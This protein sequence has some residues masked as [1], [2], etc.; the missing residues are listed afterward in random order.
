M[1][2]RARLLLAAVLM[3]WIPLGLLGLAI[4]S[5]GAGRLRAAQSERME[6]RATEVAAA[7]ERTMDRMARALDGFEAQLTD[8]NRVR[9]AFRSLPRTDPVLQ[10]ATERF[11]AASGMD[12]AFI[13][14]ADGTVAAASH[15][16][17]DVG[18]TSALLRSVASAGD[19]DGRSGSPAADGVPWVG[20]VPGPSG[21]RRVV[22]RS[23]AVRIG[24]RAVWLLL[25]IHPADVGWIVDR[26]ARLLLVASTEPW[27]WN[28]T[29]ELGGGRVSSD[30]VFPPDGFRR[31]A[32]VRTAGPAGRLPG[33]ELALAWWDPVLPGLLASFDRALGAALLGAALLAALVAPVVARQFARPVDRI[34]DAARRVHLGSLDVSF[35]AGGGREF[36]RLSRFLNGMMA[37][38][39]DGVSRVRD[40]ERRATVGELARQVNHDVRNGLIPIRNVVAHLDEAHKEGQATLSSA[41]GQR[42]ASLAQSLAYLD[43]LADQYRA[44]ATH[45][46]RTD[47]DLNRVVADVSA[48][49]GAGGGSVTLD[50]V[51]DPGPA[52]VQIDAISLRRVVENLLANARAAL[53]P[54]GGVVRLET[55]PWSEGRGSGHVL[56][57]V[58]DGPG[59][60][61]DA[62]DRVFEPFYTTRDG[63]TGL[64]LAIVRRV[65]TDVGGRVTVESEPGEGTAVTVFLRS[66]APADEEAS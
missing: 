2:F 16:A 44:V 39:R 7:W 14:L 37:R 26:D 19:E 21:D 64:G 61:A 42:S 58:D 57:V 9:A 5:E 22:L 33:A 4:R 10:T 30:V 25:G 59:I 13:L 32:R 31:L 40:A 45:G 54:T 12:V 66:A 49:A 52:P 20:E 24:D 36:D 53:E 27:S 6:A 51:L 29:V 47:T 55:A 60:P 38:L 1:S 41:Y 46:S 23:R 18:R 17:G 63:G 34:A 35:G 3:A 62:L 11:A 48:A 8:D 50:V 65:V 15:F 43:Q 28:E 56:R